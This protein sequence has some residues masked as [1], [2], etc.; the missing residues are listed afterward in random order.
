[1]FSILIINTN[2]KQID[3]YDYNW[4]YNW[5]TID[6][7]ILLI[8]SIQFFLLTIREEAHRTDADAPDNAVRKTRKKKAK[9]KGGRRA[10]EEL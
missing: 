4:V 9:R 1:M 3:I 8:F 10:E 5:Y 7:K 2:N 6:C